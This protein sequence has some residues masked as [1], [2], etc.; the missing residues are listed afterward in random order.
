MDFIPDG[1][2]TKEASIPSIFNSSFAD[3]AISNEFSSSILSLPMAILS[4]I[5]L[6]FLITLLLYKY[7]MLIP[8]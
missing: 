2:K 6:E 5:T 8:K 7:T 3:W 4:N 1:V